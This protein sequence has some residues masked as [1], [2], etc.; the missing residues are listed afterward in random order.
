MIV[1]LTNL[2]GEVFPIKVLPKASA[3][4]PSEIKSFFKCLMT[5]D[6]MV[7]GIKKAGQN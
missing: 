7:K 5:I 2:D 1:N 3:F 6:H 4:K